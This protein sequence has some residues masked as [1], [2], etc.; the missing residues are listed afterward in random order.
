MGMPP[1]LSACDGVLPTIDVV[2]LEAARHRTDGG[3]RIGPEP[4]GDWS[5]AKSWGRRATGTSEE[6]AWADIADNGL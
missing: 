5:V 1:T 3:L 6:A 2:T 4:L